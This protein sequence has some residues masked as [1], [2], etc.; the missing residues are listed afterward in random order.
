MSETLALL[1]ELIRLPSVTPN[2]AGCQTI[3]SQ[4]LQTAG[5]QVIHLNQ[6]GVH[7]FWAWHGANSEPTVVF[8]GHSD[9]V[10]PGAE[11]EWHSPPFI[12]SRRDGYL[13]GR[14]AADMK[15]GLAAMTVATE[16][17][18]RQHP[19]H[20]GRIGFIV[21]S[22]EEGEAIHGT[23]AVVHYLQQQ[24]IPLHYCIVGEATSNEQ[25]GDAIKIGRRGS[26]YGDLTVW[27]K[28]G[29]IAY[30]HLADNPI[31]RSFS[32]L[33]TLTR[34]E[35]DRGNEYFTPTSFQIYEIHAS[36]GASNM[37]PHALQVR[38]NFRYAP[39]HT[40]EQLQKTCEH[41]LE[42]HGL[43]YDV[44]WCDSSQPFFSGEKKLARVCQQAIQEICQITTKSNTYGGTSDGRFIAA[45]G[46]EVIE[47]GP[48]NHSAHQIDE[49]INMDDLERLTQLYY[50][51]LEHLLV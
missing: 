14:G 16:R 51:I 1:E 39:I 5:C 32:A 18:I 40:P 48:V 41:I 4:R 45:T 12:P 38:F 27:G 3:L 21:T 43:R 15:S 2:D 34:M 46:C 8:A 29:H 31:H 23:Q 50:R 30:P 37:I 19:K 10:P 9:V 28:Q 42:E 26:L 17:F 25:L 7:N 13:Y 20:P 35:W 6:H 47:L 11:G 24:H 22:D 36:S 44:K 33:Q 49:H